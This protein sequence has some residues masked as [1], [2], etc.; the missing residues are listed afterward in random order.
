MIFKTILSI[1]YRLEFKLLAC[2]L[3]I[4]LLLTI[5]GC[6]TT[7]NHRVS[8]DKLPS[9]IDYEIVKV[10]MKNGL[11]I[12][13]RGKSAYYVK[14]YKGKKNL[15]FYSTTDTMKISEDTLNLFTKDKTS[16][17]AID[18]IRTSKDSLLVFPTI[19]I[20]ELD[21]VRWVTIK[22]TEVD[23]GKTVLIVVA[24]ITV[25]I[26]LYLL[27]QNTSDDSDTNY[28]DH[29]CTENCRYCRERKEREYSTKTARTIN[30]PRNLSPP[31]SSL[32]IPRLVVLTWT[33]SE[34]N[35][36]GLK[37]DVYADYNYPPKRR[38]ANSI[39]NKEYELGLLA[40]NTKMYWRV[41]AK[42]YD[43][44]IARGPVWCFTTGN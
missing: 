36:S 37:Y 28:K 27:L 3:V 22:K 40:P 21:S 26:L 17:S 32:N 8:N 35:V 12:D 15:I 43:N 11:L 4:S 19:K 30:R 42:E 18:T 24:A 16:D 41:V 33:C 38:V 5:S 14:E 25:V 34:Q 44:I 7:E 6:T 31:D 1:R 23:V 2:S 20:I 29:D 9:E 10:V 39:S 13:L